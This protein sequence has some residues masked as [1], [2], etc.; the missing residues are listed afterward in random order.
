[1]TPSTFIK[2]FRAHMRDL[3]VVGNDER[4]DALLDYLVED[5]PAEKWYKAL[6]ADANPPTTWAAWERSFATRFPGPQKAER[7]TQEWERELAGMRIKME[8]LGTTVQ[9]GGATVFTHVNF[10]SKLLET[11]KLAKIENTTN[12]IWQSR[13]GLPEVLRE[14]VSA[15]Q[16]SW[17]TYTDALK[18]VEREHI[19]EGVE[20]AKKAQEMERMVRELAARDK[21]RQAPLTPVSKMSAQLA[22]AAL[23]TPR[24]NSAPPGTNTFGPGGG[25]GNLFGQ[26]ATGGPA[27]SM[28]PEKLGKLREV[29]GR[30]SRALLR[31]DSAGRAE[32]GR[33]IALWE[34][35][36]AGTRPRLEEVGFPLSP[37]T[38]APGPGECFSCGKITTPT[39]RSQ[40]CTAEKI[41]RREVTFCSI[42]NKHIRTQPIQINAVVD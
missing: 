32:Y 4:I 38:V 42:I 15:A 20:K 19:R 40:E 14:K 30:L 1:V 21:V 36:Y 29:V 12:G 24:T 5:S 23:M 28:T 26:S 17:I 22:Q 3:A 34:N 11:A 10:A 18:G 7:T 25:R 41:P 2:K 31:D 13:D 8:E 35:T 9:V 27:E 37:G 39:H 33:R 6:Q 16:A